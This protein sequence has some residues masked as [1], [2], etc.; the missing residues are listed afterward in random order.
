MNTLLPQ[1][2]QDMIQ[3]Y[4]NALPQYMQDTLLRMDWTAELA[5]IGAK[6]RLGQE[7]IT[8]LTVETAMVLFGISEP[9]LF[10]TN[11]MNHTGVSS[12]I[13]EGITRDVA[14]RIFDRMQA[15][16]NEEYG[17]QILALQDELI[18]LEAQEDGDNQVLKQLG[19]DVGTSDPVGDLS[20]ETADP[21]GPQR[22]G[23]TPMSSLADK[24]MQS[25]FAG[26]PS[27]RTIH[28]PD[29]DPYHEDLMID[30]VSEPIRQKPPVPPLAPNAVIEPAV[31]PMMVP[32]MPPT[33]PQR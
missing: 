2:T 6:H 26:V 33:P 20:G 22:T 12:E 1:A 30:V 29:A 9:Q 19:I 25:A 23:D 15:I 5:R 7:Q 8:N 32:P 24:K 17:D 11:I 27:S 13:A 18:Q 31:P 21:Q 16:I 14:E 3:E 10:H 4:L 28:Y